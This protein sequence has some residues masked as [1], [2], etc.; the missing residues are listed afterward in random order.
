MITKEENEHY[1]AALFLLSRIGEDISTIRKEITALERA[2]SYEH[3]RNSNRDPVRSEQ[4][5]G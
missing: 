3:P 5:N 4:E 1:E 2:I